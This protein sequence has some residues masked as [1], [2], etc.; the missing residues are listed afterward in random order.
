VVVDMMDTCTPV[1]VSR[2]E[3]LAY[4]RGA[5]VASSGFDRRHPQHQS[6]CRES[7]VVSEYLQG[8]QRSLAS[9]VSEESGRHCLPRR[10]PVWVEQKQAA[11]SGD[12]SLPDVAG[13]SRPE[14][15]RRTGE[16]RSRGGRV[17]A[18]VKQGSLKVP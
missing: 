13:T 3:A 18:R 4:K 11:C 17:L 2:L 5:S 10:D 12:G 6:P 8:Q 16:Q 1:G 9:V 14:W 15:Q 7:L